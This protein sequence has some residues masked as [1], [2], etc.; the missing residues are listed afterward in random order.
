MLALFMTL[1]I[2]L[3]VFLALFIFIQ[4]GKGD[5]GLGSLGA[6]SQILFGGSGGQDFFE[7]ATWVMGLL[8]IFGSLGLAILKTKVKDETRLTGYQAPITSKLNQQPI[9]T[10]AP[11]T[12]TPTQE[13]PK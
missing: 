2:I 4:H 12:E 13:I 10:N 6:G 11:V 1:F 9:K 8:F 7:K 5:M 3:C